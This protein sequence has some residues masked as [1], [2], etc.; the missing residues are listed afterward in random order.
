MII[1]LLFIFILLSLIPSNATESIADSSGTLVNPILQDIVVSPKSSS[2][3]SL[4]ARMFFSLLVVIVIIWGALQLFQRISGR[5]SG[6]TKASHVQ[7][8]ERTYIEPKKAVYILR[9]G[10]RTLAVGVT[11]A[12]INPL[13]ELDLEETLAAYP[14]QRTTDNPSPFANLLKEVGIRFLGG[15]RKNT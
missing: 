1:K 2:N 3:F 10:N 12:H 15:E 9:I 13:A 4:I 14:E 7:V 5:S 8:L 11:E 6:R